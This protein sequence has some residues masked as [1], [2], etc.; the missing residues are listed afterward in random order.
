[1]EESNPEQSHYYEVY[2]KQLEELEKGVNILCLFD[3]EL[4]PGTI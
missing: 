3:I 2:K 4:T 1:M